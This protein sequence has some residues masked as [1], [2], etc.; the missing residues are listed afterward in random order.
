MIQRK[1]FISSKKKRCMPAH[2]F[3]LNWIMLQHESEIWNTES[4]L[5]FI[6]KESSRD[7][8]WSSFSWKISQNLKKTIWYGVLLQWVWRISLQLCPS[9]TSVQ[10]F[11]SELQER[12]LIKICIKFQ[13]TARAGS[14]LYNEQKTKPSKLSCKWSLMLQLKLA[15]LHWNLQWVSNP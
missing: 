2:I 13:R 11:F 8:L 5:N 7:V 14:I 15:I 1:Q 9:Q 10:V 3:V 4:L 12:P 6:Q